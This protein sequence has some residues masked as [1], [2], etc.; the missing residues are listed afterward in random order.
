MMSRYRQQ[1]FGLVELLLGLLLGSFLLMLLTRQYLIAKQHSDKTFQAIQLAYDKQAISELLRRSI[2]QAGFTPCG[3]LGQLVMPS[4]DGT[5]PKQAIAVNVGDKQA[6]QIMRMS[7]EVAIV[8]KVL[9]PHQLIVE[10]DATFKLK[11]KVLLADCFH[12]EVNTITASRRL[13]TNWQIALK[14]A[15]HFT[16]VPPIYIGEWLEERFFVDK[17][18]S[19]VNALYY[20]HQHAEEFATFVQSMTATSVKT[21]T[22]QRVSLDFVLSQKEA[23]HLETTVRE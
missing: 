15:L 22:R 2:R 11:E 3:A 14:Q 20:Q 21:T 1:A 8:T 9:S 6:L 16:Y 7:D 12:A 5:A 23:W 10:A 17:N 4:D 19:G 13:G 18:R